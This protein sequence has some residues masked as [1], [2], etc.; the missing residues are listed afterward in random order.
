MIGR[1][2][3]IGW[4]LGVVLVAPQL[5]ALA[6]T[7]PS[8][9]VRLIVGFGAGGVADLTTRIVGQRLGERLGQA[10]VIDNRP[11]AGGVIAA[12]AAA[13]APPDGYTLYLLTNGTAIS[14]SLYKSLPYNAA[15]DFAPI[16][17]IG[18]FDVVIPVSYTHLTLPTILLV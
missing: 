18:Q 2:G 16:S 9:P 5:A 15:T 10:V 1:R 14:Q 3:L 17:Q 7:Y 11:S 13:T 8:R 12:E 4:L 6:E